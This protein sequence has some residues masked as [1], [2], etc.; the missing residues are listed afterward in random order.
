MSITAPQN[1]V[2][3]QIYPITV[4]HTNVDTS[5]LRWGFQLTVLDAAD[6]RAGN[7]ESTDSF[8]QVLND[9]GPGGNR[10]YIQHNSSGTFIGQQGGASWTFNWQAP[11]TDVGTV[12]FYASGNHANN[13]GNSSGDHIYFTFVA[14]APASATPDFAIGLTPSTRSLVPGGE[15]TYTATLT[16]LAGFTGVVDL[17]ATGLPAGVNA[18]FSPASITI[19]DGTAKTS[20]L[21]LTTTGSAPLGSHTINVSGQSGVLTHST[22]ATLNII[23]PTAVDLSISKT[24]SPNPGQV[25]LNIVYRIE[26][27]NRGPA[28]ATNVSVTD[29]LPAGVAFVSAT[30]SQGSCSGASQVNCVVGTLAVD[31]MAVISIV[32][33]PSNQGQI[34][35]VASVSANE[36]DFDQTNNSTTI[37]TFVEPAAATPTMLDPNLTVDTVVTG[38]DQPTSIAFLDANDFLVLEKA[39]GKVQRIVNGAL[40]ATVLDLPVNSASERGLLGIALHNDFAVNGFVYLFWTESSSGN[41]EMDVNNAELL[42]NRVDRYFWNGSSLT[43]DRNLIRLRALQQDAGQPSRGNHNGGVLRFG[44]DGKLYIIFGDVGR[45]GFLQNITSGGPVPDDQFG[46]PEPDD[47][48]MSGV[49]LRLNDDGTTPSDN[50]FFN[51]DSGLTGEAAANVKKIFAYGVRNSFGMAFDPLSGELWTQENGDDAFDEINRVTPGFNGGWIQMMGPVSRVEQFR[52]IE[53]TYGAGNLQQ[54]RWPPN[55]IAT[56]PQEAIARL[57]MLPGAQYRDPEFSWKYAVAPSPIG[58][59]EGRGLGPKFEGDLLVG[60]SRTTLLNGYLFRFKLNGDRQHFSF[61]DPLLA[62][63]VAD[64]TDKFDLSESESLVVGRDFGITTDV[65]TGPNGSVYVV[66]LSN[67]AVYEI[68]SKPG[69]IFTATLDGQQEVPAND[70]TATGT[71]TLLLSADETTAR[72]SL[73]FSGLSSA[74]TDAHIHGPASPGVNAG[75]LFPLPSGQISDFEITLTAQQVA[76]L[77]NGLLYVNVHTGNFLTGEIR[78]QFQTS[79]DSSA[80]VFGA[81]ALSVNEGEQSIAIDVRRIGDTSGAATVNYATGD[82]AGLDNCSLITG[83]ASSRCDYGMTSGQLTFSAGESSKTITIPIVDDAYVEGPEKFTVALSNPTGSILGPPAVV[84]ITIIDNDAGVGPN[85]IDD[86]DFFVRQHYIDF[87]NREP[88]GP[89]LAFW[90]NEI[91]LCGEDE[92]CIEVKRVNVSAAFFLSIEFQQTG[93]LVYRIY[94]AAYGNISEDAPVP[95]RL[96]EF[97]PDTQSIAQGII[98]GQAN[99]E[100]ELVNNKNA[101]AASFVKRDRFRQAYAANMPTEEFVNKLFENAGV[102]PST[103]DL[104]AAIDEFEGAGTSA[105]EA[106]R[107]RALRRVAE[108]SVFAQQ[109]FN[110]AFVLMQYFGYLRRNPNAAPD[111]NFDGYNFWLNKLNQFNGNFVH[112][113]MVKA[114]IVAGEYRERFGP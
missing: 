54:N 13:D 27:V 21:T 6:E 70:S 46:G 80:F 55:N 78:G 82:M 65:Q 49:I 36:T 109:E 95:L 86:V 43:F 66:S 63:R 18:L 7:L 99:W 58:F 26:V 104:E 87:L 59:V 105:D 40:Q 2:P 106:A 56:S 81:T 50:P 52:S 77:K 102:S 30:P 28:T 72:L 79:A 10:Q 69:Q 16:P 48:H 67:G 96:E 84:T 113:E 90:T 22:Q 91:D 101:F 5:R 33:T 1:Y 100:E 42:A 57:Y 24:A 44:P 29:T 114:F 111:A 51:I 3:G 15:T 60:A 68:K 53:M 4:T 108:N 83:N 92:E 61:T 9:Q 47:A 32:V 88:D 39:S 37:N 38:L 73:S 34:V 64:N 93:Y 94:K 12:I 97:L 110:R 89:G 25:G 14:S 20:T 41:D 19:T 62:D 112:A 35:N 107:A 103:E 85:P 75:V 8:T 17:S 71:A 23:S 31:A 45:R 98:V 74:Q 11:Q 76:D